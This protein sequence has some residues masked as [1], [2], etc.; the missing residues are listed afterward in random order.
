M[1]RR[2]QP[3]VLAAVAAALLAAC[4]DEAPVAPVSRGDDPLVQKVIAMGFRP[5]MIEDQG[6]SFQ[7]EGDIR[8]FKAELRA[9]PAPAAGPIAGARTQYTTFN[10][11][12]SANVFNVTV[13]LAGIS[14]N[15]SW[16]S[17]A[18]DAIS[19]WNAV[20]GS[21]V[22]MTETT[23]TAD[24][25]VTSFCD[26]ADGTLAEITSWPSGGKPGQGIR[27][28]TC[29]APFGSP[30]TYLARVHAMVHELGHTLGFRHTNWSA[31]GEQNAPEHG[32]IGAVHVPG[33]PET[34]GDAASVMNG[35]I[36]GT[37]WSAFS[38]YDLVA[39]RNRYPIPSPAGF[40][41]ANAGGEV[42]LSWSP[43]AG[44][45]HYELQRVERTYHSV[46]GMLNAEYGW[47][48]VYTTS[49]D[50]DSYHTGVS[51]CYYQESNY[52]FYTHFNWE[53]R[54]VFPNG[55]RS[56]VSLAGWNDVYC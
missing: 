46:M 31:R 19:H 24:I 55:K 25:T 17:A 11:V 8:L 20:S 13:N 23:G 4:S 27:A 51:Y 28:N 43:V 56:P 45:T 54:A 42:F 36:A 34:Q 35:G 3:L 2:V 1:R 16:T 40:T 48:P 37:E 22:R 39:I 6:D 26:S 14:G 12:S 5:D 32:T 9:M 10:L 18:R 29:W 49:Y 33:T 7:V 30:A 21:H 52:Y 38:S 15:A 50:T 47:E 41:S 53:V 44:A